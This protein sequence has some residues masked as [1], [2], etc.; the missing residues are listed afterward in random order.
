MK[1]PRK[2]AIRIAKHKRLNKLDE[3]DLAEII[4]IPFGMYMLRRKEKQ[5]DT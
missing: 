5:N 4:D 2:R 3:F 1:K